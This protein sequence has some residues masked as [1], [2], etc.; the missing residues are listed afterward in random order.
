MAKQKTIRNPAS[1]FGVGLHTGSETT[2]TFKPAPPD[3][4]VVF[5]RIDLP[6]HPHIRADVAHV[7]DV[8]RG[9]TIG[10]DGVK[11]LTIEHVLA[12]FAGLGID[13]IYAEVNAS[14]APVGDG[15]AAPFVKVLTEAGIIEQDR[16]R[17]E[18]RITEAVTY[19]GEGVALMALPSERLRLSYTIEYGHPALGTQFKS[20]VIDPEVF[21]REIAPARTF[22]FLRDVEQLKALGLIKGGSIENAVVIGDEQILNESLRF[23]DE[24]VRHKLLDLLGD[25]VLLG[26]PLRGHIVAMKAGHAAHVEFI[27]RL[28]SEIGIGEGEAPAGETGA[29]EQTVALNINQIRDIIP[30]RFP[31]LLVDRITK[32]TATYACGIKNVTI[33]EPYFEG[34]IPGNPIMPGVLIIEAMAQVGAVLI[35]TRVGKLGKLPFL[36]SIEKAKFRKPIFPGDQMDI[37]VEVIH[38]HKKYGRLRGEVRVGGS[39][40]SEAEITFGTAQ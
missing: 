1:F 20:F 40:A 5:V 10:L 8:A 9:T 33:G 15:S 6:G 27:K 16:P 39:L 13:N 7:T 31:M 26:S 35:L 11:V 19:E 24:F 38:L 4:G 25:L 14:E 17:R 3:T 12:A 30:H 22:C 18:I 23:G 34:H 29:Q 2:I 21:V 37:R 36:M 28:R 32:L